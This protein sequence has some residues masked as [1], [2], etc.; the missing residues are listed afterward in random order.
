VVLVAQLLSY[1]RSSMSATGVI[2]WFD[3]ERDQLDGRTPLQLLER[4]TA[5]AFEPLSELA[6]GARA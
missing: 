2:M 3:A 1:L 4:D 5:R 6:R